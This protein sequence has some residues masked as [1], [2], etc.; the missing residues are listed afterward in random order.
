MAWCLALSLT[1]ACGSNLSTEELNLSAAAA[2]KQVNGDNQ[3]DGVS[4][5]GGAVGGLTESPEAGAAE[6]SAP[7]G[8][9]GV[10][11]IAPTSPGMA[12]TGSGGRPA[13]GPGTPGSTSAARPGAA[14]AAGSA[15]TAG[16]ATGASPAGTSPPGSGSGAP[17]PGAAAPGT[18]APASTAAPKSEIVLGSVGTDSGPFG[19]LTLPEIHGAKAWVSDVNARGGLNGHPVRLIIHDDG[20]DPSKAL[21]L[22]KKL[23]EQ[24]KVQAFYATRAAF[25]EQAYSGYLE[26]KQIPIIGACSCSPVFDTSPMV[27]QPA[28]GGPKGGPWFH[29][30]QLVTLTNARNISL[31]YCREAPICNQVATSMRAQ[32][33]ALGIKMIHEAQVS[34][35]QPDYTAEVIA[36][37]NAGAE[38]VVSINDNASTIRII[39][40]MRRQGWDAVMSTQVS[41]HDERFIKD[42]GKDVEGTVVSAGVAPWSTSPKMDDYVTALGRYVPGGVRS[43]VG[44]IIWA[45]GKLLEKIAPRFGEQVTN[46]DILEGLYS[47]RQETLGGVIAP[48]TWVRGPHADT[49][50]CVVPMKIQG[51][52][53]VAPNGDTFACQPGWKPA[54]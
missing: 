18:P 43:D 29:V 30:G 11:T 39:R 1:A 36:A 45:A 34:V 12:A 13:S 26:E 37:R 15:A 53:F 50:L 31:F 38:A 52:K 14:A 8:S 42:G 20:G 10:D 40:T 21:S 54:G 23:V 4:P 41:A 33:Q 25:T 51:G 28:A 32:Q 22:A 47:L 6:G 2:F 35:A 46:V 49:N 48:T 16:P 24:D 17:A 7:E 44:A 3:V 27:F 5:G 19:A 9:S